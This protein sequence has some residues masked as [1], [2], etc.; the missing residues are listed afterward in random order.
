MICMDVRSQ[1]SEVRSQDRVKFYTNEVR[2]IFPLYVVNEL[3][4]PTV[5]SIERAICMSP[6]SAGQ[7]F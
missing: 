5:Q 7:I 3:P 2:K 6:R 1:K 4:P